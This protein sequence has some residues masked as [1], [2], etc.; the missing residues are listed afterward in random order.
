MGARRTGCAASTSAT[1]STCAGWSRSPTTACA[2]CAYCGLRAANRDVDALPHDR[3]RDPRLRPRRPSRFGYGTVVL[4]AGEDPG[5]TAR[6]GSRTWSARIKAETRPGRH[7]QP[8]RAARGG[9]RSPGGRPAPTATCCASRPPTASST[10]ASTRRCRGR[11]LRPPRDLLG[12][13]RELG[14][15]VG[16]G[17]MVGIPGQTL[18]RPGRRHPSCSAELDLDMIGVGPFLPHPATPLGAASCPAA[19]P[20]GRAGPGHRRS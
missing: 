4:Q 11:A 1:R 9:P 3:R 7:A 18:R 14:Y 15:E 16:S 20:A 8:R 19:G 10:T 2:R 13:L 6:R 5:L 12:G 17:V